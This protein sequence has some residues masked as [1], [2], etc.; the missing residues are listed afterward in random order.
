MWNAIALVNMCCIVM[1]S[2]HK[3]EKTP[4]NKSMSQ[5]LLSHY[6]AIFKHPSRLYFPLAILNEYFV[7][8]P[9]LHITANYVCESLKVISVCNKTNVIYSTYR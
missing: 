7:Y 2:V 3:N 5:L 6:K 4:G 9:V 1:A 8:T